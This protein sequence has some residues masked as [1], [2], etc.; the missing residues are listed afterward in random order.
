MKSPPRRAA[1]A[2]VFV[3]VVLDMMAGSIILPVLPQLLKE[4]SGGSMA[5]MSLVYGAMGVL[6]SGMQLFAGPVQGALSDRYGR[7]PVILAS[8]FGLAAD[9]IIMA[10]APSMGWLFLGRAITG[11][12]AGSITAAYAYVA[13]V[14]EPDQRAS[15]FGLLAAAI[16]AGS[17]AGPLLGGYLGQIDTRAPFW[18]A[19]GLSLLAGLYGLLVLPESLPREHRAPLALKAIHP[20]GAIASVWRD[21]PVIARWQGVLFLVNLAYGGVNSIFFLYVA[22]RFGWTPK[23]IGLYLTAMTLMGLFVNTVLVGRAIK[24]LGERNTIVTGLVI[25]VATIVVCGLAVT[26]LQFSI[27]VMILVVG[28]IAGPAQSALVQRIISPS[29]RGRL[30]GADRSIASLTG[31]VAPGAFAALFAGVVG[32]GPHAIRVGTPFYVSAAFMLAAVI[33]TLS[34]LRKTPAPAG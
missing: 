32:A 5:Q 7:R 10:V 24:L 29:D 23:E 28:N 20:I 6:F 9:F 18:L 15:R 1:M 25:Q 14:S 11:A 27:A 22:F 19:A 2:F 33:V 31:I 8:N 12:M 3:T 4:L 16:S 13:D 30:S 26:G 34:A 21:Y 17:L